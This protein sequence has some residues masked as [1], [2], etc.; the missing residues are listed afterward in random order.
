MA[1]P[2]AAA[3]A[4]GGGGVED[5]LAGRLPIAVR[6]WQAARQRFGRGGRRVDDVFDRTGRM[7]RNIGAHGRCRCA[8]PEHGDL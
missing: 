1:A 8:R 5:A 6:P 2:A 4:P 7:R 3:C